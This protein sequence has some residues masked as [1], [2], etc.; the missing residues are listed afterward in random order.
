MVIVWMYDVHTILVHREHFFW[1]RRKE[2][3]GFDGVTR[4]DDAG[5]GGPASTLGL[6][7]RFRI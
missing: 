5:V 3:R 6:P 7:F 2:R 1:S 4:V